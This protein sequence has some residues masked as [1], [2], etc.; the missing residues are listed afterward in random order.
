M[1]HTSEGLWPTRRP[2]LILCSLCC[3]L[4]FC[5]G[6]FYLRKLM[7]KKKRNIHFPFLPQG[8]TKF[9][10]SF[11]A[12]SS[13]SIII[14]LANGSRVNTFQ[15]WKAFTSTFLMAR[16]CLC[17]RYI[18]SGEKNGNSFLRDWPVNLHEP[19]AACRA[20]ASGWVSAVHWISLIQITFSDLRV[21]RG[22]F[23]RLKVIWALNWKQPVI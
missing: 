20:N 19:R 12:R 13:E 23:W 7:E 9:S 1:Y 6:P 21:N 15:T 10:H 22:L 16:C 3:L 17:R 4:A 14:V 2:P 5:L 18:T 8:S 11:P